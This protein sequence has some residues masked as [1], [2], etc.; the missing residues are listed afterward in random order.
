MAL[1]QTITVGNRT[2]DLYAFTG[3]VVDEKKW[4]TTHVSGS[5]G[6]Y[7]V[8]SGQ[9]NPITI[10]STTTTHDQFF[11][12]DEAGKEMSFE[13]ANTGVALRKGH[14]ITVLW[15]IIKGNDRGPNI[16]VYNHAT[17]NLTLIQ[18]SIT[19]L[20][21]PP[22]PLPIVLA[23]F[24]SAFAACFYGLGII[25]LVAL[26]IYRSGRKKQL[27]AAFRPAVD[28]AVAKIRNQK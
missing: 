6:G 7:N 11:I 17:D 2:I 16:A 5:G 15:G 21:I 28:A 19:G 27:L 4:A 18:S 1:I 14:R 13:M 8:G 22:T 10:S 25:A 23:Y 12:R 26:L 9:N 20:A 3:E 24:V